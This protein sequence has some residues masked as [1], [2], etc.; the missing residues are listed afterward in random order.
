MKIAQEERTQKKREFMTTT[1]KENEMSSAYFKNCSYFTAA[2]YMRKMEQ[3]ANLYFKDTGLPPAY[4]Y[5]LEALDRYD[6]VNSIMSISHALGYDRSS[7][8]RMVK[9]LES[10]N[11]VKLSA[12]G[13]TT[14]VELTEEGKR[15]DHEVIKKCIASYYEAANNLF[16]QDNIQIMT[17]SLVRN[18]QKLEDSL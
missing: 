3:M 15:L 1:K 18:T 12:E 16:G 6:E 4:N 8:S 9:Q 14:K 7:I 13:R 5:I 10:K 2:K 11:L 17:Q